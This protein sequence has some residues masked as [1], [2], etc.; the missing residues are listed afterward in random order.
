MAPTMLAVAKS[1]EAQN[2]RRRQ[3]CGH[4]VI[5]LRNGFAAQG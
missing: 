4:D 5:H 1:L 2:P 3:P